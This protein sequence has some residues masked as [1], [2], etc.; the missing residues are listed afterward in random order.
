[1]SIEQLLGKTLASVVQAGNEVIF[2]TEG[3]GTQWK[4]HHD[5]NCCEGVYIEDVCGDLQ[6]LVGTPIRLAEGV[7]NSG[8]GDNDEEWT[9]YKLATAKGY[10]TIRWYGLS[11][12]YYSTSVDFE[13]VG[14]K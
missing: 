9:F 12:G 13:K 1:M 6:D 7:S 3:D 8:F 11:N 14:A 5:Q 4:M 10:V 2:F